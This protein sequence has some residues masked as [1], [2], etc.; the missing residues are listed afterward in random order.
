VTNLPL[1]G[2]PPEDSGARTADRY[3]FQYCCAA[4]RLLAALA[5]DTSCELICEW[6][7]DYLVVGDCITEAVSVK[8]REDHRPAWTIASLAGEDGKLGHLLHTFRR[9]QGI[10][11]CFESNRAHTAHDLWC[12]DPTRRAAARND[13]GTRLGVSRADV[14]EFVGNLSI[15]TPPMPGRHHIASTYAANYASPALDRLGITE[16]SASQAMHIAAGLVGDASRDRIVDDAWASILAAGPQERATILANQQLEARRITSDDLRD[17]LVDAERAQIPRLKSLPGDAPPETTMSRK[18]EAG[19][20][21]P[22]VIDTARRR[23]RLWYSHRAEVRDIGEREAELRSLQEWVQDQANSAESIAIA[24]D[25]APYGPTM[26]E[27]LMIRL[28]AADAP[29]SGTRRVDSDPALLSGA[30]FELTDSCSIWW[31]PRSAL[32][33]NDDGH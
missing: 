27:Q 30:A 16:L 31:S 9:A 33:D 19:G 8:H 20:L 21:G 28:R 11:C 2:P 5:T 3:L 22:S 25:D 15:T 10:T 32:E 24:M 7:E 23:R 14:D 17:A 12:D 1:T 18:L 26:Y 13:L 4:A 6:H 29:P